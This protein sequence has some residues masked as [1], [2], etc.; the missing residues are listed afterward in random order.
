MPV[1]GTT[2]WDQLIAAGDTRSSLHCFTGTRYESATWREVISDAERMTA[3]LRRAGVEPGARVA[4]ILTNGPSAV[5]GMLGVWLGGGSLASLPVR[6]RGMDE[7]E[8]AAQLEA[9]CDQLEPEALLV[10]ERALPLVPEGVKGVVRTISWE[11]VADS[12]RA[13]LCPP[14]EDELAFVQYSSGSTGRPKGCMLTPRAIGAQLALAWEMIE[15]EAGREA[16]V[17]WLPLSH[18]MG[19]FGCLL[20]AWAHGC[21]LF[22]ST[23]ERFV[24][25]P[26]TWF[27]DLADTGATITAATN[28][29][30]HLGARAYAE[31][32]LPGRLRVR[33]LIVGAERVQWETLRLA[34]DT[35]G[36]AGLEERSLMPAYGLAEATLAVTA[37]ALEEA[38]ASVILDAVALADG[39][40]VEAQEGDP[41][42]TRLVSAGRPCR[43]VRLQGGETRR[44]EEIQVSSPALASGYYREPELTAERFRDGG[45]M[46]G[47]IGFLRGGEL[48]PVGRLDDLISVGGRNVYTREVESAVEQLSGVR[49]GC[50]TIVEERSGGGSRLTLCLEPQD[51]VTDYRALALTAAS[52]AMAKAAVPLDECVF[53]PRDSLPKT[54][55]GKIQRHRARR[56]LA[57]TDLHPLARVSLAAT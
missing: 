5:R 35:F 38:P 41:C 14:G 52:V 31:E 24:L 55:S 16:A 11:S 49:R 10:E 3:G 23:P 1:P 13:S 46:T 8:Y 6:A 54:P 29:A 40:L 47:D 2:L 50:T 19:M 27:G 34:V 17:S 22:L 26:R 36:A 44:L 51:S 56:L 15:G 21:D 42:G 39:E 37:T 9:I 7:G 4:A 57:E 48:Y 43:D 20:T 30:L 25:S 12:G 28:T 32:R 53:L 45:L 33:A 18:D